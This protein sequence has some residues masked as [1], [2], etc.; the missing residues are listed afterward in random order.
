M[1]ALAHSCRDWLLNTGEFQEVGV[2]MVY[3]QEGGSISFHSSD[4]SSLF[5]N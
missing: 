5:W 3:S 2:G 4:E 1:I